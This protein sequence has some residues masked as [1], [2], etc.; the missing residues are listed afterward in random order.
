[1]SGQPSSPNRQ[2]VTLAQEPSL[3]LLQ[4]FPSPQQDLNEWMLFNCP[5]SPQS[6][7]KSYPNIQFVPVGNICSTR[8]CSNKRPLFQLLHGKHPFRRSCLSHIL[9]LTETGETQVSNTG[10]LALPPVRMGTG[11]KHV[12]LNGPWMVWE[13]LPPF[14]P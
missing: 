13:P 5:L 7:S 4:C 9:A 10:I 2:W 11:Q 14:P 3:I 1:M 8:K 6:Q 12:P